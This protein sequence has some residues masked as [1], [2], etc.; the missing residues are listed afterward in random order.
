MTGQCPL[1]T[2]SSDILRDLPSAIGKSTARTRRA[3][4]MLFEAGLSKEEARIGFRPYNARCRPPLTETAVEA[5]LADCFPEQIRAQQQTKQRARDSTMRLHPLDSPH[6]GA[7]ALAYARQAIPALILWEP[8]GKVCSCGD[9]DCTSAGKH[10]NGDLAPHGVHSGTTDPKIIDKWYTERPSGN[11]GMPCGI[12]AV[13]LDVDPRHGGNESLAQ[14]QKQIGHLPPTRRVRTGGDGD[15]FHFAVPNRPLASCTLAPGL[16]FKSKGLQVVMPPSKH[17]SGKRYQWVTDSPRELAELPPAWLECISKKGKGNGDGKKES[18]DIK[19]AFANP[20]QG[21]RYSTL[22]STVGKM[23]HIDIPQ[24]ITLEALRK[25]CSGWTPAVEDKV[26]RDTVS[27]YYRNYQPAPELPPHPADDH[28]AFE[29]EAGSAAKAPEVGFVPEK[30][31][32]EYDVADIAAWD[33]ANLE[34]IIEGILARGNLLWLAAETQTGKTLFMLW[35]CLQLLKSGSLFGKFSIT[36]VK[37][38]LYVA[39]EDPARRFKS[40]LLDM[41]HGAIEAGRFVIF[42]APGL[43]VADP[44]S[45][46]FLAKM[47]DDGKYELCILDTFQ[48]ATMGIAS[49][50]DEKLSVVIRRLLGITRKFGT[51]LVVSDHFRKTPNAKPRKDLDLNDVKGSGGKLQNAD[52]FLLMDRQDGRLR[53]SGRSKEWDKPIGFLLDIAAQGVKGTEK[54]T[55]AGDLEAFAARSKEKGKATQTAVLQAVGPE[56]TKSQDIAKSAGISQRTAQEYLKKLVEAEEVES[57]GKNR[58]CL[59]R[60]KLCADENVKMAQTKTLFN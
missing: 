34:P 51:T 52:V 43:S 4:E 44:G 50:D 40:R 38:I 23:R 13:V 35:V 28:A 26:I 12:S 56:W 57:D 60:R 18:F 42:V 7:H 10:P 37:K 58:G 24:E 19:K 25:A 41:A 39:C 3:M 46:D 16:E 17:P 30:Y 22:R 45:F 2:G 15:H 49:Y 11:I 54:F 21:E 48:A 9:P 53:I 8:F 59:Y 27:R 32:K 36:P 47:I 6:M 29:P 5:L 55:Y 31:W 20:P 14:L 33:C 1:L